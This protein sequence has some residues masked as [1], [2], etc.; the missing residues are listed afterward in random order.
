MDWADQGIA[1]SYYLSQLWRNRIEGGDGE[2]GEY[3]P[4]DALL[5]TDGSGSPILN[6]PSPR[7]LRISCGFVMGPRVLER[8]GNNISS[9]GE[10][11]I[12]MYDEGREGI[13]K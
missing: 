9:E 4:W 3:Y 2:G 8:S 7:V 13:R 5:G 12:G 6:H 10:V 1:Q 11:D